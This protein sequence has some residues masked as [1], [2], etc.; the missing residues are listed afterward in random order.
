MFVRFR[1]CAAN[2]TSADNYDLGDY[3]VRLK[4]DIRGTCSKSGRMSSTIL[5]KLATKSLPASVKNEL[6]LFLIE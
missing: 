1:E 4:E 2:D 5:Y 6:A 3:T